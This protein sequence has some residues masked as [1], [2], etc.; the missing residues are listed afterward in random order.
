MFKELGAKLIRMAP[1]HEVKD[2][3]PDTVNGLYTTQGLVVWSGASENTIWGS[4]RANWAFRALHDQLH[5]KTG[6][7]FS[8]AEEIEM[9]R[10]QA[11][12]FEGLMADLVYIEVAGQA[13]YYLKTGQFVSDQ[14]AFTMEL[15]NA[16]RN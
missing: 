4:E 9:G 5:L 13:E 2:L 8:P 16:S 11:A 10:I 15:L 7:G 12:K 14:I 6:L 3:A 1:K